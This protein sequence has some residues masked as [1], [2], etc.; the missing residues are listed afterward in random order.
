MYH[1][2]NILC[3]ITFSN[4]HKIVGGR[5]PIVESGFQTKERQFMKNDCYV[6]VKERVLLLTGYFFFFCFLLIFLIFFKLFI[7]IFL[8]FFFYF[9]INYFN[10]L[11]IIFMLLL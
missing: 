5:H 2:G 11:I 8:F 4:V 10:L 6:G 1:F 7:F 9:I 3:S